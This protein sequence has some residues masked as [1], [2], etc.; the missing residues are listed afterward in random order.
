MTPCFQPQDI[1]PPTSCS[2]ILTFVFLFFTYT[3][4]LFTSSFIYLPGVD[5]RL[6]SFLLPTVCFQKLT[7]DFLLLTTDILTWNYIFITKT[8]L[9]NLIPLNPILYSE[10]GV[11]MGIYYFLISAQ[12]HRL[13]VFI[14]PPRLP[15]YMFLAEIWKISEFFI[16][17]LFL[18]LG[19]AKFSMYLNRRV[20]VMSDFLYYTILKWKSLGIQDL[21][22]RLCDLI[23][24]ILQRG[25]LNTWCFHLRRCT[26]ILTVGGGRVVQRCRVSY[27]TGASN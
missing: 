11:Y 4:V 2:L 8:Y 21:C 19:V 16:R 27:V 23:G 25:H 3:L 12:K 1:C 7:L 13:W 17:F 5:C 9:Y 24:I 15:Q 26:F 18:F 20:F 22:K 10:T 14:E 6:F